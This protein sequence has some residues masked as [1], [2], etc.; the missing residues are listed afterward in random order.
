MISLLPGIASTTAA[1]NAERV[2]LDIISQN[3]ANAQTTRG[4]DGQPY[5]RQQ[6]VFLA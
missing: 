5:V 6:V 3:I 1:L 4:P 2:R